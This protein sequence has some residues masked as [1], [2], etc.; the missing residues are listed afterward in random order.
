MK[1]ATIIKCIDY[2][3][4]GFFKQWLKE[5]SLEHSDIISVVGSIKSLAHGTEEIKKW[6]IEMIKTSY[7][8]HGS[9]DIILTCHSDCGAYGIKDEVREKEIQISDLKEAER[10]VKNNFPDMSIRL[11]WLKLI[12]NHEKTTNI[13]FNQIN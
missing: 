10:I 13:I 5:N 9:R 8:L 12:G 11:Y 6:L 3:Q 7:D 1:T 4:N 2:R